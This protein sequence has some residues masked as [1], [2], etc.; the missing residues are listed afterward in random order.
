MLRFHLELLLQEGSLSPDEFQVLVRNH[1]RTVDQNSIEDIT[2]TKSSKESLETL[3]YYEA[4]HLMLEAVAK[5]LNP[6]EDTLNKIDGPLRSTLRNDN[7]EN[8]RSDL[9]TATFFIRNRLLAS[10][11]SEDTAFQIEA[12]CGAVLF[13]EL[14]ADYFHLYMDLQRI[15]LIESWA[16]DEL[17]H[18]RIASFIVARSQVRTMSMSGSDELTKFGVAD[19]MVKTIIG[20]WHRLS[21]SCEMVPD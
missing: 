12:R 8:L 1:P 15:W 14:G 13:D 3:N 11:F 5:S 17:P 6:W 9:L 20:A 7:K 21:N 19:V 16:K 10:I 2:I 18:F 4:S